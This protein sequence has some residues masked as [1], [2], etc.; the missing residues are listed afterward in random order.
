MTEQ[1]ITSFCQVVV[2][3]QQKTRLLRLADVN[4]QGELKRFV[5]DPNQP[6]TFFNRDLLYAD[7][8]NNSLRPG[9]YGFWQWTAIPNNTTPGTD[10]IQSRYVQDE[11]PIQIVTISN[12]KT[13]DETVQTIKNGVRFSIMS[14]RVI[15]IPKRNRNPTLPFEAVYCDSGTLNSRNGIVTIATSVS[16]ASVVTLAESEIICLDSEERLEI[17]KKQTPPRKKHSIFLVPREKIICNAITDYF[18]WGTAKKLDLSDQIWRTVR[19]VIKS[20]Y[21]KSLAQRIA[22]E[23]ECSIKEA[24]PELKKFLERADDYFS[25][26]SE[27]RLVGAFLEESPAFQQ[28][29]YQ[30]CYED[31]EEDWSRDH[32]DAVRK[33]NEELEMIKSEKE[34][35]EREA[36][37]LAETNQKSISYQSPQKSFTYYQGKEHLADY[38]AQ[39]SD[40]ET[41]I[42]EL[43]DNLMYSCGVV[44]EIRYGLASFL[45]ASLVTRTPLLLVGA[46]GD[47]ILDALSITR[48][49]KYADRLDCYAEYSRRVEKALDFPNAITIISA[50]FQNE[51]FSH[52]PQLLEQTRQSYP[53]L[54]HPYVE[55]MFIEP[56]SLYNYAI[57]V[58]TDL[59]LDG[60]PVPDYVKG[61]VDD[62]CQ[63]EIPKT[64]NAEDEKHRRFLNNK[65]WR[66]PFLYQGR[67]L[68]LLNAFATT[69]AQGVNKDSD[70]YLTFFFMFVV[71]PY[72]YLT[73]ASNRSKKRLD[74]INNE[75]I[76]ERIKHFLGDDN[77]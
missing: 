5:S 42:S 12:A 20:L 70:D 27:E 7:E 51:W 33:A 18:S 45:V 44:K 71:F 2:D 56:P 74:S 60:V 26:N 1:E 40:F 10:Y 63:F 75:T 9:D 17:Y 59:L 6:K 73:G 13:L 23:C 30:A 38:S 55:D 25:E 28:Q 69:Y 36:T 16:K 48:Y 41:L 21:K 34:R 54:V 49:G 61:V 65:D 76:K 47:R 15:F 4:T 53:C 14:D 72:L 24:A 77:D 35:L 39:I 11:L 29:C 32:E 64:A 68:P 22:E 52:L 43:G 66:M 62:N 19:D 67:L 57:P 58:V 46:N 31:A 8:Q 37:A 50:P 3:P